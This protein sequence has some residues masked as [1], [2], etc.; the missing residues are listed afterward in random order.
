MICDVFKY[1]TY[2]M[3]FCMNKYFVFN[4]VLLFIYDMIFNVIFEEAKRLDLVGPITQW[5]RGPMVQGNGGQCSRG[6]W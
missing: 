2:K 1:V 4:S 6:K 5:S 3:W